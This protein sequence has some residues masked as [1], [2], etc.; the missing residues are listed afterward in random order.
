MLLVIL[1]YTVYSQAKE[2]SMQRAFCKAGGL[3]CVHSQMDTNEKV[4]V[5]VQN[6][7]MKINLFRDQGELF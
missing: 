3:C 5:K 7:I 4:S 1:L 2:C 6:I